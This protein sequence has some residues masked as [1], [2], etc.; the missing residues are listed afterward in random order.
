LNGVD[1]VEVLIRPLLCTRLRRCPDNGDE[2]PSSETWSRLR[3]AR[4]W[5]GSFSSRRLCR[6]GLQVVIDEDEH[7]S[8]PPE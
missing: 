2:T 4:M 7:T 5:L 1:A 6:Q 3:C 8:P